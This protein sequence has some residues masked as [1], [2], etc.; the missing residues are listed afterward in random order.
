[1]LCG[2]KFEMTAHQ[3]SNSRVQPMSCAARIYDR[4]EAETPE[5]FVWGKERIVFCTAIVSTNFLS[6]P[7]GVRL[8]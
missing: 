2:W 4:M 7:D 5:T 6:S 8:A 1:M 3:K